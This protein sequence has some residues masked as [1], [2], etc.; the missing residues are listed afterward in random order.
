MLQTKLNA[1]L[2]QSTKDLKAELLS[3]LKVG[4]HDKNVSA[5]R[6]Q[7][8]AVELQNKLTTSLVA[9]RNKIAVSV[10]P[11][12]YQQL[13]IGQRAD[14]RQQLQSAVIFIC[15]L[16]F[17]LLLAVHAYFLAFIFSLLQEHIEHMPTTDLAAQ[18]LKVEAMQ[19]LACV[20]FEIRNASIQRLIALADAKDPDPIQIQA[21]ILSCSQALDTVKTTPQLV[22]RAIQITKEVS[23]SDMKRALG[24]RIS[25]SSKQR[26]TVCFSFDLFVLFV[27]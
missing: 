8:D 19:I 1:G 15:C 23:S 4:A 13:C 17:V 26:F 25:G 18:Q 16:T 2:D 20:W 27:C 6:D 3:L 7:P 22:E 21:H 10:P 5:W 24:N 11:S 12:F 14:G 9:H